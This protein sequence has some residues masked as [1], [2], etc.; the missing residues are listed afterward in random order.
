MEKLQFQAKAQA[1]CIMVKLNASN[2]NNE[3]NNREGW[4]VLT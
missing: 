2:L 3:I 1:N 4:A